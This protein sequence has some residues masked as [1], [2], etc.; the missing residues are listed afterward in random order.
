MNNQSSSSPR[1]IGI[2]ETASPDQDRLTLWEIFKR[3][4]HDMGHTENADIVFEFRWAEGRHERLASAAAELVQS[5]VDVLVTSGTPAAAAASQA[6]T[7]IPIIMATGVGLGTRLTDRASKLNAN[8]TGISDLPAGLSAQRLE[9]LRQVVPKATALAILADRSNPSSPLA[10]RETH[11]AAFGW[12]IAVRDYWVAGPEQFGEALAAM[13]NDG[14]GGFVVAPGAM[15]FAQR[16]TLAALAREHRLP[17]MSVR[18]EYVEAG[19]LM[20][21]GASILENYRQAAVYVSRILNGARAADIPVNQPTVFEFVVNL[22]TAEAIGLV[23]PQS[24]LDIA[25]AIE[26]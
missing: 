15:F 12:A 17:V 5:K 26:T 16:H 20:A 8:V 3:R 13:R 25:D 9:R 21:Y 2:L 6:T 23:V 19:C 7:D 18:R 22:K 11:A 24:L 4:L 1:R 10:V 14:I